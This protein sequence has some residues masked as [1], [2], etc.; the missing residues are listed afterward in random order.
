MAEQSK[1]EWCDSTFNSW[2]GCTKVSQAC[3]HCYAEAMMDTRMGRVKWGAGQ[4]RSRTS[5]AYWKQPLKWNTQ[6]FF[7]CG[8]C[9]W[10]GTSELEAMRDVDSPKHLVCMNCISGNITPTRRRVFCASLADVFDNEVDP[11]WRADLFELIR[12]TPNLDW[13]LLTKRIGNA[14]AMIYDTRRSVD[15]DTRRELW[16]FCKTWGNNEHVPANVWL[17]ATVCNQQEADHYV[18]KLLATPAAK[19]FLSIEPM[20]GPVDLLKSGDTLCRCDGCLSMASQHPEHAGLQRIDWIICGGESGPRARPSH[21]DWFRS[22]RD[23]CAAAGVPFMFKQWGTFA[24]DSMLDNSCRGTLM[25]PDGTEMKDLVDVGAA[26]PEHEVQRLLNS[27]GPWQHMSAVGKK[28][29][30][31]LLDGIKHKGV[32]A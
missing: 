19:R 21:P 30:G 9:G 8:D 12:L 3:D 25:L 24:P 27:R 7:Q 31:R 32:P 6:P 16:L 23:Q 17:G 26:N 4:A 15:F 11:V 29:A 1:I 20:L 14:S 2:I 13:L 18:P 28:A 10:R 22:L 5:A